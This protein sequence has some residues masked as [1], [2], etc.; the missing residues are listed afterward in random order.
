MASFELAASA[1]AAGVEL[2]VRLCRSGEVVVCHDPTLERTT[3]GRDTRNVADLILPDLRLVDVGNGERVPLLEEVLA[4]ARSRLMLVNV[5][6]KRDV[7]DRVRLVRETARLLRGEG[8]ALANIVVSSFDPW[9]LAYFGWSL[10]GAA[11]G[12]L[13]G[14]DQ[15]LAART[16][17][18]IAVLIGAQAVHPERTLVVPER[19]RIWKKRGNVINVWTVN[20]PAEARA[21]AQMGVDAMVTDVPRAIVAALT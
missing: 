4:W 1:G 7:P 14:S 9:M 11:R 21:L 15:K 18:F 6:L 8:A 19:C 5:E 20:D 17:G 16:S 12:W 3:Q 2:D 10:P 13:F